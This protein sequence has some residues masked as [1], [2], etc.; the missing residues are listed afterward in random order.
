MKIDALREDIALMLQK[1]VATKARD[2]IIVKFSNDPD[3]KVFLMSLK[4]GVEQVETL[5]DYP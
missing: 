4:A 3:C 2:Q 1:D 5:F